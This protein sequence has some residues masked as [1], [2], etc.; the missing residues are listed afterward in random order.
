MVH[1]K[2]F[3]IVFAGWLA[4]SGHAQ[5]TGVAV[6]E[7]GA[8]RR[9]IALVG[10]GS[11]KA[12]PDMAVIQLGV[13]SRAE[14]ARKS[15][16]ENNTEMAA[17][18]KTILS[19]GVAKEDIQTSN[20]SIR[21]LLGG[22][23]FFNSSGSEKTKPT[24]YV[25]SNIVKLTVRDLSSIDG[26]LDGVVTTGVNR[27]QHISFAIQNP[28]PLLDKARKQAVANALQ[29]ARLYAETAGFSLGQIVSISENNAGSQYRGLQTYGGGKQSYSGK[30]VPVSSGQ[31]SLTVKVNIVWE[32][33]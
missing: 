18:M 30:H 24:G 22:K 14:T 11:V 4:V 2:V 29:K 7:T 5:A 15:L 32:I 23:G 33:Q 12:Q 26:V 17:T 13:V 19:V 21:P 8:A 28:K 10:T 25:V 16:D 3:G 6:N 1:M 31:T 9:T 20:F 27:I